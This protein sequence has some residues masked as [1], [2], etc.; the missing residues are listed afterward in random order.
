MQQKLPNLDIVNY[1]YLMKKIRELFHLKT[2][3]RDIENTMTSSDII[4]T[5]PAKVRPGVID[6]NQSIEN[7]KESVLTPFSFNIEH[8][9]STNQNSAD[10]KSIQTVIQSN[11]EDNSISDVIF[12]D[13]A[14]LIGEFDSIKDN[15][16]SDE[17]NSIIE[18]CQYRIIEIMIKNGI[19]PI[20]NSEEFNPKY[21]AAIPFSIV[22][23][24][25]TIKE[26]YRIGLKKGSKVYLKARVKL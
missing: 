16:T 24:G 19:T 21:H 15:S 2:N 14:G 17:A 5:E 3:E 8:E 18:M 7:D 9:V 13:L 12:E 4:T 22:P 25:T 1:Y 6:D 20:D 23:E 26:L 10:D 11:Q